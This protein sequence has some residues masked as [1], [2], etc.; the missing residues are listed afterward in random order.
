M[1]CIEHIFHEEN[2]VSLTAYL[3]DTSR[4]YAGVASRP[5]VLVI[6]GGGYSICS[7]RFADCVALEYLNAGFHA[8]VLRYT[9]QQKGHWPAP[10]NDY[11]CA[12]EYILSHAEEWKVDPTRIAVC[13]SS[14]GGHL[15]ACAATMANHRPAAA[16]LGYPALRQDIAN[17]CAPGMPSPL[18]HVDERTCPCFIYGA[19][20][21]EY[22]PV[23]SSIDLLA[24][25]HNYGIHFEV[26]IYS[27]GKHGFSLARPPHT[28]EELRAARWVQDSIDWL[29]DMWGVLTPNG[30]KAPV[31]GRTVDDNDRD[32]FSLGCTYG[33]LKSRPETREIMERVDAL[34][35]KCSSDVLAHL[36]HRTL[37]ELLYSA[38][39]N[40]GTL[41]EFRV[42]LS[43]I[44]KINS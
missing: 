1:K 37:R 39:Y 26:H 28:E 30:C 22:V 11:E 2:G 42:P 5:A 8:F 3:Q 10:L 34:L 6:P 44:K 32:E 13:G 17:A 19:R 29:G 35:P 20:D 40:L 33:Y 41:C 27:R 36:E 23:N 24:A 25:L 12:M 7:D 38:G 9:L 21:D 43:E 18:D 31:C 15:A 16:I 4:E 14:A